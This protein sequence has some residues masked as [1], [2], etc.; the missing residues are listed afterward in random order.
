MKLLL[1]L[2]IIPTISIAQESKWANESEISI[3][4]TGG[5][6]NL[7]TYNFNS[8]ISLK[9]AK[10]TYS[11]GGHYTLGTSKTTDSTTGTETKIETARNWDGHAK[12]QQVLSKKVSG[13]FAI[14]YEGDE[15]SGYKQRENYDVG[16]KYNL[17]EADDYNSF[18]EFGYRYTTERTTTRNTD[19]E[20]VFNDNKGRLYYEVNHK[21]KSGLSYKFWT[22]YIKNFTRSEDYLINFEPSMA[23]T[24]SEVFSVKIAY[25][26]MYDNE[27]AVEGNKYL[28]WTY[29]TSLIAVF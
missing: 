22:E 23:F 20:D 7:E 15:F 6:T 26:G 28:D 13:F 2:C 12:Y 17:H 10:R 25:K 3:I 29:T 27:P 24:L 4:Q 14:Q 16:A 11:A 19:N 5:N 8:D 21:V 1:L 9:K 18:F